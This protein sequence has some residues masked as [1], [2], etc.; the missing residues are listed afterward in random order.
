[1]INTT[2]LITISMKTMFII[3]FFIIQSLNFEF[4]SVL[5]RMKKLKFYKN[6]EIKF[7]KF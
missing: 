5:K 6:S 1:M 2:K 7:W 4:V 3:K